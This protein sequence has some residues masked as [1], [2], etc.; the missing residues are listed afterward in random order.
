MFESY[1]IPGV[2]YSPEIKFHHGILEIKGVSIP[3]NAT[4]YYEPMNIAIEKYCNLPNS[5]TTSNVSLF[6]FNLPEFKQRGFEAY[7]LRIS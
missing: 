5:E 7:L 4:S 1:Y 2:K 3:E 6:Y